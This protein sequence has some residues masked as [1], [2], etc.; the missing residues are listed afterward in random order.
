MPVARGEH[1]EPGALEGAHRLVEGRHHFVA[2]RHPKRAAGKE[3]ALHVDHDQ[4]VARRGN[5]F[6]H[7]GISIF[8]I[9]GDRL[10]IPVKRRA[11]ARARLFRPNPGSPSCLPRI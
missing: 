1:R 4:G 3:V 11:R 7:A 6:R 5:D 10:L 9:R 8:A 2:A